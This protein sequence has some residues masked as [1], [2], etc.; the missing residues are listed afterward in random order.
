MI[1]DMKHSS[2]ITTRITKQNEACL[3]MFTGEN[4]G[5]MWT[6]LNRTSR[7]TTAI[8]TKMGDI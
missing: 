2:I 8:A 6:T 4:N 7:T 3:M 1:S 5:V